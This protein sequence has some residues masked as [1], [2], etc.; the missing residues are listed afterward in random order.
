[1]NFTN[2]VRE[3]FRVVFVNR[4]SF[5]RV[6]LRHFVTIGL[7]L[8]GF[9]SGYVRV[10]IIVM[11]LHDAGDMF[12]YRAKALHYMGLAGLA[13]TFFVTKLVMYSHLV[14]AMSIESVISVSKT[15]ELS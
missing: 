1:M 13:V 4:R 15:P 14:H 12:L 6:F 2:V 11:V 9:L 5:N 7:F 8:A 10:G 3:M